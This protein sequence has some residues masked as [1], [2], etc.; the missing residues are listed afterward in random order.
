MSGALRSIVVRQ[1]M[2]WLR[3]AAAVIVVRPEMIWLRE[4]AAVIHADVSQKSCGRTP[5]TFWQRLIGLRALSVQCVRV[6]ALIPAE[7]SLA[8]CESVARPITQSGATRAIN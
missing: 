4:A 6:S 5:P 7:R 1:E 3:E 8:C 2:I